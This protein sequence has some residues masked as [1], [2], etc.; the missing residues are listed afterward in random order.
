MSDI[1]TCCEFRRSKRQRDQAAAAEAYKRGCL[2]R[3]KAMEHG[4]EVDSIHEVSKN[5]ETNLAKLDAKYVLNNTNVLS[6]QV[7]VD[8]VAAGLC[9]RCTTTKL[10]HSRT[11]LCN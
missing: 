11:S 7:F 3:H 8:T 4:Q 9:C 10:Q 6:P 2:L 5:K 1:G